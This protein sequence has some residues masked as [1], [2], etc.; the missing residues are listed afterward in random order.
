MLQFRSTL[1]SVGIGFWT[2][3]GARDGGNV[4]AGGLPKMNRNDSNLLGNRSQQCGSAP[5]R[6]HYRN[7]I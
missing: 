3:M 1:D 7:E 2:R 4:A 6:S 5:S